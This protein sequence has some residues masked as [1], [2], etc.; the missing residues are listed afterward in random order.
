MPPWTS[1]KMSAQADSPLPS[2]PKSTKI[3]QNQPKAK[4]ADSL[5]QLAS[6]PREHQAS[7]LNAESVRHA[8]SLNRLASSS[9]TQSVAHAGALRQPR[10]S[11][12]HADS[13]A[14]LAS[15]PRE[16]QASVIGAESGRHAGILDRLLSS[17]TQSPADTGL[18]QAQL[19]LPR[20]SSG[21]AER[22]AQHVSNRQ[23]PTLDPPGIS[24]SS[25]GFGSPAQQASGS[26][27][28]DIPGSAQLTQDLSG[29]DIPAKIA[30]HATTS[31]VSES[32]QLRQPVPSHRHAA[33]PA[34]HVS[35]SIASGSPALASP[36]GAIASGRTDVDPQG[37]TVLP[38]HQLAA[39][40]EQE[41]ALAEAVASP[42]NQSSAGVS[43]SAKPSADATANGV[44][45]PS[46]SSAV[47]A[48]AATESRTG[49]DPP[50]STVSQR[51]KRTV[52]AASAPA[53]PAIG[54]GR[55]ATTTHNRPA[56]HG[57]L[58]ASTRT[59]LATAVSHSSIAASPSRLG[60]GRTPTKKHLTELGVPK[61]H[62]AVRARL[63]GSAPS[64]PAY[65][66]RLGHV[67]SNA[68]LAAA[69]DAVRRSAGSRA[70]HQ[71]VEGD[72]VSA[73][74]SGALIEQRTCEARVSS[75]DLPG[76]E[77]EAGSEQVLDLWQ[78]L[79]AA[80]HDLQRGMANWTFTLHLLYRLMFQMLHR[81]MLLYDMFGY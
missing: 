36:A 18:P 77:S 5:A 64:S 60:S 10:Q 37:N 28:L 32:T 24:Q 39:D 45:H 34:R 52:N 42:V 8:D 63:V 74:T 80:N 61:L 3:R 71:Y 4:P 46:S 67:T 35:D 41:T 20:Q 33:R 19:S 21:H 69:A 16:R 23:D 81:K 29:G 27:H 43:T 31:V 78:E 51:H 57:Q 14:Q 65:G 15:S 75:M 53:S 11:S 70:G 9:S 50:Q 6:S 49:L 13:S 2:S 30:E 66:S 68:G 55:T 12:G 48:V 40:N 62:D 17:S 76:Q 56:W 25:H 38:E 47:V 58:T 7:Q 22:S 26:M 59:Q 79:R 54:T 72:G 44:S 73:R 1:G